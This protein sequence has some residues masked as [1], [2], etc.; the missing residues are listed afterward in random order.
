M[1][2]MTPKEAYDEI[3]KRKNDLFTLEVNQIIEEVVSS[4][5]KLYLTGRLYLNGPTPWYTKRSEET[6][7]LHINDSHVDHLRNLG[8]K[9]EKKEVSVY[10]YVRRIETSPRKTFL[11]FTTKDAEYSSTLEDCMVDGYEISV[12]CGESNG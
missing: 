2:S 1:K 8:Y 6:K 11:G 5:G 4:G 9:V 3:Q 10:H 12:C 7:H